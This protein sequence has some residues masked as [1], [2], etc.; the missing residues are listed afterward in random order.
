[1][2]TEAAKNDVLRFLEDKIDTVPHLEALLLL[3]NSRPNPWSLEEVAKRLFVTDEAAKVILEDLAR[4]SLIASSSGTEKSYYYE[5][6]PNRD[7][8]IDAV[9]SAY[10]RDLI[11]ITRLIHSKPSAAVRNFARAFRLKKDRD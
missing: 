10:Q 6:E 3:W 4:L 2:G 1:M 8:L 7:S 5:S 11:R 9:A